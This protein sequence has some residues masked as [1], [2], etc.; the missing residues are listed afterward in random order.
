MLP[1]ATTCRPRGP[2][3][4]PQSDARP[5]RAGPRD[6]VGLADGGPTT[7]GGGLT[8]WAFRGD[9][10]L[11]ALLAVQCL[12]LFVVLPL[13]AGH[14]AGRMLR[15]LCDLTFAAVSAVALTRRRAVRAAVLAALALLLVSTSA[16]GTRLCA[17][18][19]V[20][21]S[22]QHEGI[23]E[24]IALL[25]FGFNALVTALVAGRVF[26]P[27][28]VTGYRLLGAV[29]LYL[30]VAALFAIAFGLLEAHAPGAGGVLS[31]APGVRPAA[32]SYY[33]LA[34]L[35]TTGYG[36]LVPVHP[37]ARSLA[38]LES[39]FGQL[40]PATLLARLVALH[41]SHGARRRTRRAAE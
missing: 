26:G 23:A 14:P 6:P 17:Q 31:G 20:T 37:L 34:T 22:A 15:S 35:T 32:L 28:R 4:S 41:L 18:F 8:S 13:A 2:S 7:G 36:D 24:G 5:R 40:F 21:D 11:S 10:S 9:A 19:G 39:V 25:A 30:N 12:T 33:S 16:L 29:V 3:H 1:A 38:N 27:G